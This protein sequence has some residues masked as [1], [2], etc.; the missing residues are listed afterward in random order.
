MSKHYH[1]SKERETS[2]S[3]M[4]RT[5][6]PE[7]KSKAS[8]LLSAVKSVI[9]SKPGAHTPS[10]AKRLSALSDSVGD[11]LIGDTKLFKTIARTLAPVETRKYETVGKLVK[12][13]IDKDDSY[14]Y[15]KFK[16]SR[17]IN[18]SNPDW[19]KTLAGNILTSKSNKGG[20][21]DEKE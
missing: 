14:I 11:V 21:K 6:L 19:W 20:I 16:Q 4:Q 2:G 9:S 12:A 1:S 7:A 5:K 17:D 3:S 8:K 10:L 18:L 15:N 13:V